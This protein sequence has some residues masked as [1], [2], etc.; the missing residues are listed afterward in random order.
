MFPE[1]G[2]N[3]LPA[4]IVKSARI[5][6]AFSFLAQCLFFVL[7]VFMPFAY[8]AAE[9]WSQ[10]VSHLLVYALVIS[11]LSGKILRRDHQ[12][13]ANSVVMLLALFFL[14]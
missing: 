11:W 3:S 1:T 9:L 10:L 13:A 2:S 12:F 8:G 7:L 6:G 14:W 5:A 4:N